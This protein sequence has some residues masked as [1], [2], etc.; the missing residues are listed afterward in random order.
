MLRVLSPTFVKYFT[1]Y[2]SVA[3]LL[4]D[5]LGGRD[6]LQYKYNSSYLSICTLSILWVTYNK[7]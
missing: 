2:K 3:T 6:S 5:I 4:I 7:V 1:K